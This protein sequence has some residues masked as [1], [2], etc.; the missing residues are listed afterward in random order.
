MAKFVKRGHSGIHLHMC[1]YD[2]NRKPHALFAADVGVG[3]MDAARGEN[4][5]LSRLHLQV[6]N[7]TIVRVPF[8][9]ELDIVVVVAKE[10]GILAPVVPFHW[11]CFV[12]APSCV[13]ARNYLE[14]TIFFGSFG[15]GHPRREFSLSVYDCTPL[16]LDEGEPAIQHTS[17]RVTSWTDAI[18]LLDTYPLW[19]EFDPMAVHPDFRKQVWN[20]VESRL[21]HAGRDPHFLDQWRRVCEVSLPTS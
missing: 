18:A 1:R 9:V 8:L 17:S 21:R 4:D 20:E 12:I 11:C 2:S 19:P 16:F 6:S 15:K 3:S 5:E 7:L 10:G 13:T 14:A